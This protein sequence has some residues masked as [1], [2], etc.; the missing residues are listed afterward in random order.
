MSPAGQMQI[1]TGYSWTITLQL[2]SVS[3]GLWMNS[4]TRN[5]HGNWDW[6]GFEKL[7]LR[8]QWVKT[9]VAGKKKIHGYQRRRKARMRQSI[10]GGGGGGGK[11]LFVNNR[12]PPPPPPPNALFAQNLPMPLSDGY[13]SRQRSCHG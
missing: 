8:Y 2:P 4:S 7:P 10:R 6:V 3:Q 1:G 11:R 9:N 5:Y 12:S 13:M